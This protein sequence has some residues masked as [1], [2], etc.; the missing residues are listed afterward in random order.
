MTRGVFVDR[1]NCRYGR[2]T[3]IE[4]LGGGRWL[5]QCDCGNTHV[6]RGSHLGGNKVNSCGC[7]KSERSREAHTIHGHTKHDG[8]RPRLYNVWRGMK[9]RCYDHNYS[10]YYRYGGRGITVCDEW[11]DYQRFY[12][13]AMSSGYDPLAQR[14]VC[15]LDRI[16]NDGNYCPENCRWVSMAVQAANRTQGRKPGLFVSVDLVDKNGVAIEHFPS[17]RDA[18]RATGCNESHISAVCRGERKH[19][20]GMRWKYSEETRRKKKQRGQTALFD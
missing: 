6:V 5:C 15:T 12:E 11:L 13:W 1:T 19:T 4:H 17:I 20:L 2:L 8:K 10:S 16:D 9:R 18:S 14:G 7:L 3:A